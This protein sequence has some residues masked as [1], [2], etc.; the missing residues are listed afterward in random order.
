MNKSKRQEAITTL[1]NKKGSVRVSD[2]VELLG[3][4]DMTVRRDLAE[5]EKQGV[6]TKT[7]G[8]ARTNNSYK[9]LEIS[10]DEK[11]MYNMAEKLYIAKKASNLI[12][13][14]D[15]IYL[16][17]GTTVELL[18]KEI[19][20]KKIRIITNCLPVFNILLEKKTELFQV[21]LLGGEKRR[22]TEAFVGEIT[23][24]I[25]NTMRF[26]KSFF[27]ANAVKENDVMASNY[28]EAFTQTLALNNSVEKYLLIDSSKID[29]EDFVTF[30]KLSDTTAV[31]TNEKDNDKIKSLSLFTEVIN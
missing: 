13:D 12:Q 15:T 19:K 4:T 11:H 6:L 9:Y 7:H 21:F 29:R 27:G 20:N 1:V 24:T 8:G 16:G 28:E 14:G 3:V 25:L 5:L 23:Y 26:T 30:F 18:A 2:I 17:P 10:H 22:L 31:I